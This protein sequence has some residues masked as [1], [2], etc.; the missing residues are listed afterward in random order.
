MGTF[1]YGG[2]IERGSKRGPGRPR[3][4]CK[5]NFYGKCDVRLDKNELVMLEQ[6]ADRYE[7]T[8]S[9]IMR[10]ALKEYYIYNTDDM[11]EG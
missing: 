8:R 10:K 6:L 7:V 11:K 2:Y 4:S 5:R 1:D 9:D 3:G